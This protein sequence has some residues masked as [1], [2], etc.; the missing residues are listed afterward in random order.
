MDGFVLGNT[1]VCVI[2]VNVLVQDPAYLVQLVEVEVL[3]FGV[4][5]VRLSGVTFRAAKF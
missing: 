5:R 1:P 4:G 2:R 3:K